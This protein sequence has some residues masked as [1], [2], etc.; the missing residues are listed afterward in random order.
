MTE[1]EQLDETFRFNNRI[2]DVASRF[3]QINPGQLR[4][5]IKTHS[6]SNQTEIAVISEM[7][8]ADALHSALKEVAAHAAGTRASVFL[9]ARYNDS[10]PAEM[11]TLQQI[12]PN[13]KLSFYTAHR[14]KG[15]EA[16]YVIIL[17]MIEGKKGF[18]SIMATDQSS[19]ASCPMQK[20][21][22]MPK[23]GDC[24]MSHLLGQG[25]ASGC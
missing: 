2:C 5:E 18:P 17:D 4:K 13:L 10:E 16:D 24:S 21:L 20:S 11:H 23:K 8:K 19:S 6:Q 7:D 12:Y 1:R 14:S 15:L 25:I 9:L 3:V 22:C